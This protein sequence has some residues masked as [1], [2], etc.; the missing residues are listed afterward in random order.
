M[1][2]YSCLRELILLV[3][4]LEEL[5][6]LEPEGLNTSVDVDINKAGVFGE[7]RFGLILS[8]VSH[9]YYL[10][11]YTF[12]IFIFITLSPINFFIELHIS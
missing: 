1:S 12:D 3:A 5:A 10:K 7:F 8:P 11:K 4:P 9:L 2:L 6:F